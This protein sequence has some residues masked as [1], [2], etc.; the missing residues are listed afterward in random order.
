MQIQSPS[1]SQDRPIPSKFTC[2]GENINPELLIADVPEN[3]LSLALIFDDPDSPSGT[4]THWTVWNIDPKISSIAENSI[5]GIEGV[6]SFGDVKY[7]GPCPGSGEH[8]YVFKLYALDAKLEL[9][10]GADVNALLKSMEGHILEQAEVMG[11]Y[12]R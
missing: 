11:V 2:D 8:R 10:S 7:G 5:P 1:F 4:W 3:A 9:E 6:T 12:A